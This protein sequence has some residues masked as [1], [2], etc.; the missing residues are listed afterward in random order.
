MEVSEVAGLWPRDPPIR[1]RKSLPTSWV[2]IRISEGKNRQIRRMTAH[3][4]Y[5]TLRLIRYAIG[6][7]TVGGL[8]PGASRVLTGC[9][10]DLAPDAIEEKPVAQRD[11]RNRR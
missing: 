4:G 6:S 9:Y 10:A 5:P 3:V 11:K 8:A 1:F 7:A 2:E